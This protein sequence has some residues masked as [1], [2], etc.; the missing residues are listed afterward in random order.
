MHDLLF[1]G[2]HVIDPA[3]GIN[4]V[5]DIAVKDGKISAIGKN[6]SIADARKVIPAANRVVTPGLIDM[7]C[8]P[9]SIDLGTVEP[10]DI[11]IYSGVTTLCEGGEAGAG[12]FYSLL[13]HEI[14]PA[15][16]DMFCFLNFALTGL[17]GFPQPEIIDENDI[18]IEI[19]RKVIEEHRDVIKGLKLRLLQPLARGMGIKVVESAKKFAL[20]MRLPLVIH[21]GESR[22]RLPGD[23]IDDF[24]RSAVSLMDKG[25]VISHFMT[26]E[27]GGLILPDGTIY[28]E[29]IEARKRGV[30]L[31][32]CT[33]RTHLSFSIARHAIEQCFLPTVISTDTNASNISTVQSLL[34]TMSKFLNLGLNIEQIISMT[35]SNP[36]EVL[37]ETGTRGS[38]KPGMPADISVIEIVKGDFIFSD[39]K[40]GGILNGDR[41]IEP[42]L[43]LKNGIEMPCLSRYFIP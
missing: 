8:H 30:I 39:G 18:N 19:T 3:Q 34:V 24:N 10:D 14:G 15:K 4:G 38:L 41:L 5:N 20:E 1:K 33:G 31:D 32:A 13:N 2:G 7:H 17:A 11:G 37:G 42:R 12:N 35:T 27:A 16:T 40:G 25:D 6:I 36:A 43:V 28:P 22:K 29:L 23:I 9:G 26:W 21:I